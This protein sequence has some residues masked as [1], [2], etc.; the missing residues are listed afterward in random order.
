MAPA[1]GDRSMFQ[2]EPVRRPR[3]QVENQLRRAILTGVF[4]RG[5]RLP[6]ETQLAEQ[7]QVSRSTIREALRSLAEAG[8]ISKVP[9]ANGGSFVEYFDH[10]HL[11]DLVSERLSSTLELGSI[12]YDEVA[13]FRNLLEV[14]CARLAALNRSEEHLAALHKVVEAE[15]HVTVDDPEVP[16]YNA[17][18]H[19][20]L[21]EASGNRLVLAFVTALHSV[22]HPLAFI[23]TSPEVGKQAVSHH[24]AIVGAVSSRDADK[25]AVAM[26]RHL[27]YLREHASGVPADS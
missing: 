1:R 23:A 26:E 4:P 10:H 11:A 21:A 7:F 15:K 2:V 20:I 6:S 17:E 8:L 12:S 16:A 3:E 24:I 22:M 5:E 13:G 9:G 18:F 19:R 25:A 14:P 27:D